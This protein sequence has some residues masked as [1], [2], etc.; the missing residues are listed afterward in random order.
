MFNFPVGGFS[1]H[2][3]H[4]PH[5]DVLHEDVVLAVKQETEKLFILFFSVGLVLIFV[6]ETALLFFF[7]K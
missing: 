5:H 4:L 6:Q 1:R 2:E 7:K 3:L